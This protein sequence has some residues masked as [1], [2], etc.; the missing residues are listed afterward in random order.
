[1]QLANQLRHIVNKRVIVVNDKDF[2]VELSPPCQI[3]VVHLY[4]KPE[5]NRSRVLP[6]FNLPQPIKI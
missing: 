6:P 2:Q 3:P 1:M 4:L 5:V